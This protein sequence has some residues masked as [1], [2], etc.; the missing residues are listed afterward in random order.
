LETLSGV[1]SLLQMR[2]VRIVEERGGDD[3]GVL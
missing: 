3:E 1:Y 2:V